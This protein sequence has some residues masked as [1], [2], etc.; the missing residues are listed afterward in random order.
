MR[1]CSFVANG[2]ASYGLVT[3]TGIVD[4]GRR[5][6]APSLKQ[7]LADLPALAKLAGEKPDHGLDAVQWLPVIPDAGKVFSVLLNY[8]ALRLEAGRPKLQFPH[9]LTRFADTQVGH[10]A[11]LIKPKIS[12]EFDFEGELAVVIGKPGR[13]IARAA[14]MEHVAGYACY[15]D[16]TP[17]D[18]MRHSRHFTLAKSFPG[19]GGFG[20]WL[21]TRDALPDLSKSTLTTR[22]NGEIMQQ[23][24][25]GNFTYPVEELISYISQATPLNAGDVICTGTPGGCGYKR[26]PPRFLKP[27]DDISVSIDGIGTLSNTVAEEA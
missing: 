26:S 9:L 2:R 12:N 18:W 19:T 27:G 8:E 21:T 13:N 5:L 3:D 10:K 6:A 4:A 20:P 25:L 15:N 11:A 24:Q 17:R 1:L 7:A 22:L 23:A 16:A 14:A